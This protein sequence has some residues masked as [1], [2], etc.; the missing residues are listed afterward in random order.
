MAKIQT[1]NRLIEVEETKKNVDDSIL[2]SFFTFIQLTE[3]I[4]DFNEM[5]G[6]VESTRE[7]TIGTN[8]IIEVY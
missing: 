6:Y 8:H 2:N 1:I 4:Y 3:K 5:L 7:I